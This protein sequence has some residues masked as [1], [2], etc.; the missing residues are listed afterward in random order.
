MPPCYL[1]P[2]LSDQ[3]MLFLRGFTDGDRDRLAIC[4]AMWAVDGIVEP[5]VLSFLIQ[6][7]L[8]R[9][10]IAVDFLCQVRVVLSRSWCMVAAAVWVLHGW[11][12][13]C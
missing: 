10:G 2:S 9:E 8:V 7:H 1:H 4:I 12:Y 11:Y 3:S 6:E 5:K 13:R